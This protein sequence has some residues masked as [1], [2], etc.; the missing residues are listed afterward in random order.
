MTFAGAH[1]DILLWR[2]AAERTEWVHT[3]GTWVGAARQTQPATVDSTLELA[4]GDVMVLYTDGV[5]EARNA[6]GESFGPERLAEAL[7]VVRGESCDELRDR[8]IATLREFTRGL[9]FEDDVTLLVIR[10]TS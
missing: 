2:R 3:P 7:G 4:V 10:R 5:T 8:V 1:E 6:E 9:P